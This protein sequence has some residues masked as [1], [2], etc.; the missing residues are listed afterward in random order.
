[1]KKDLETLS[2]GKH[3]YNNSGRDPTGLTS[4]GSA[5]ARDTDDALSSSN[6][7]LSSNASTFK[8]ANSDGDSRMLD[9][10]TTSK[11]NAVLGQA[12]IPGSLLVS[13][14][15]SQVRL[16]IQCSHLLGLQIK[17]PYLDCCLSHILVPQQRERDR[18]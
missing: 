12:S 4:F 11:A 6:G 18:E 5:D 8:S 13:S 3:M 10:I 7:S 9:Q 15:E 2:D 16:Q 1:M 17:W 14:S